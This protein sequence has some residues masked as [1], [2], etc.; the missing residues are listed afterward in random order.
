MSQCWKTQLKARRSSASVKINQKNTSE[1]RRM[2]PMLNYK[3]TESSHISI[4]FWIFKVSVL[5]M[6]L[7]KKS[8]FDH[9]NYVAVE[10]MNNKILKL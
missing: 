4:P 2:T 6:K 1:L 5:Y 8:F 10:G 9:I 3:N 7:D